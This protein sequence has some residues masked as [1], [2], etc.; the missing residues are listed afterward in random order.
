MGLGGWTTP[1]FHTGATCANINHVYSEPLPLIS[2]PASLLAVSHRQ[3]THMPKLH[4]RLQC[5]LNQNDW[6]LYKSYSWS[7]KLMKSGTLYLFVASRLIEVHY[8]KNERQIHQ[9][10]RVSRYACRRVYSSYS[11]QIEPLWLAIDNRVIF[12]HTLADITRLEPRRWPK[13]ADF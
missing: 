9:A 8:N 6:T 4:L 11:L 10:I 5:F 1:S 3:A 7:A 13:I 2:P 12:N